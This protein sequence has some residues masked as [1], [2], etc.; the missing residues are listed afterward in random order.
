M[1]ATG[2]QMRDVRLALRA[3]RASPLYTISSIFIVAL[4]IGS[5]TTV[6][7]FVDGLLLRP[8][9]VTEPTRLLR[10]WK[11]DPVRRF[12][13]YPLTYPEIVEWERAAS[14]LE[15][16]AAIV[17]WGPSDGFLL[18]SG[19]SERLRID[20]VS[21][22]FFDVLGVEASVGR[23]FRRADDEATAV[24]PLVLS[25]GLWE[26]RFGRDPELVGKTARLVFQHRTTYE[27]VGILPRGFDLA[28]GADAFV[29][30]L[31]AN[32]EWVEGPG[33]ECDA[34]AR[35]AQG[36][37]LEQTR[38]ELQALHERM[39]SE[40]PNDYLPMRVSVS[41]LLD[42]VV[43][44]AGPTALLLLGSVMVLVGLA[45]VNLA[46]LSVAQSTRRNKHL[47]LQIALGAHR[48]HLVRQ[49]LAEGTV[50]SCLGGGLGVGLA[51]IAVTSI[52]SWRGAEIPRSEEIAFGL[53]PVAFACLTLAV[54]TLVCT[55]YPALSATSGNL[56]RSLQTRAMVG[57]GRRAAT[58]AVSAQV[59]L[60]VVLL[61][62]GALLVRTFEA[63]RSLDRGLRS[64]G[65]LS[66]GIELPDTRYATPEARLSFV[67]TLASSIA[68]LP[69]V[70]AVTPMFMRP[71]SAS[72]GYSG[73]FLFE[74]QSEED[75]R[76]NPMANFEWITPNYFRT[77]GIP[78]LRGRPFEE[79][80]LSSGERVVIVN[81]ATA[82]A[83]WPGKD[84]I[85]K[86]VREPGFPPHRVVGV[87]ADT[88]YRELTRTW[89]SLY[90]PLG[91]NP[92][93]TDNRLHPFGVPGLLA[94]RTAVP[95]ESVI[96]SIKSTMARMEPDAPRDEIATMDSLFERELFAPRLQA[97]LFSLFSLVAALLAA[98][99]L[100]S[101]FAASVAE[102]I[103]EMGLRL[104]LG[105]TPERLLAMVW[106][107][108]C[109]LAAAGV[110]A[111]LAIALALAHFMNRFL[112]GVE[113]TDPWTYAGVALLVGAITLAA[114]YVPARRA[115]RADPLSL[116]RND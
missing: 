73:P 50:L 35:M 53:R 12:D 3:L 31:A 39:A 40:H 45:A 113:A 110:V 115:G 88:R 100:Y 20:R 64:E 67:K 74:G 96:P 112:Y 29:P 92:F 54:M 66:I 52:L 79:E 109:R 103:S 77:L 5:A 76:S 14:S 49:R 83:F 34:I 27:V 72:A 1:S 89:Q 57:A 11:F 13:H 62:G 25:Y 68:A 86:T 82:D 85:G 99:G 94:V 15:S 70:A 111:G 105:A 30:A 63:Q 7:T 18:G 41:P 80:D 108:A 90:F 42:T 114:T 104:A 55:L 102:R 78:L 44:D 19:E 24:P 101:L 2:E 36:A 47:A 98:V 59:A 51:S 56:A 116:L 21:A 10:I 93:S 71:G 32:P 84:P 28:T 48:S 61:T 16:A 6:F 38:A 26:R 69:G 8:L 60:A 95:P 65:L 23:T 81:A 46:G 9:R 17:S 107:R 43:G 87:A 75:F 4:G 106:K 58:L 97:S 33:C 37:T 22:N 91:Q